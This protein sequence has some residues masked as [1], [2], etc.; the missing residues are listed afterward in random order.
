LYRN[1]LKKKKINLKPTESKVKGFSNTMT[2]RFTHIPFPK[3]SPRNDAITITKDEKK[4]V[5][6]VV[7]QHVAIKEEELKK[8][9]EVQ[10]R[11]NFLRVNR[12]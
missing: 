1:Q 9:V 6:Q 8:Q 4:K 12:V 7:D 2:A 3:A 10:M 11:S 5:E